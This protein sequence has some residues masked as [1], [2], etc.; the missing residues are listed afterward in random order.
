MPK[1]RHSEL[2]GFTS[3]VL[4]AFFFRIWQLPSIPSGLLWDE[5][6]NGL[7]VVPLFHGQ[8]PIF[9]EGHSGHE[10]LLFYA[11]AL[12]LKLFGW[13]PLALRLPAVFLT[14][15]AVAAAFLAIR[16][17]FGF[18]IA[19][20][21]SLL[22]A[23][24]QW[25]VSMGRLGRDNSALPLFAAVCVYWL[26]VWLRGRRPW[27]AAVFCGVSFG[28]VL[29]T[30]SPG[31]FLI[32]LLA[33]IWLRET[34]LQPEKRLALIRQGAVF[35]STGILVFAPLGWYF[36]RHPDAFFERARQLSIFN[37]E[38]G[39]P[40]GN[41][42]HAVRATA[43]MFSF[44]GEPGWDKTSAGQPMFDPAL[45]LLFIVGGLLA[46]CRWRRKE[47]FLV[48]AWTM[49]ML[50]PLTLTA[51]DLPDW[52]RVIG[53]AP[54][55]FVFPVLAADEL[56]RVGVVGRWVVCALAI[57]VVGFNYWQYFV[58]WEHASG[59][60]Q[61]YRPG[62]LAA[63]QSAVSSLLS[64]QPPTAVYFGAPDDHDAVTDFL[65]AGLDVQHPELAARLIGYD[66]RYTRV[67]PPTGAESYLI[68]DGRPQIL[69]LPPVGHALDATL[70][71]VAHLHGY[72]LPDRVEPGEQLKFGV[73]W[74]TL[75]PS[76]TPVTFFAHVLDFDQRNVIA[77]L[78]QNGFPASEWRGNER[79]LS[80]FPLQIPEA[81][82]DGAYWL[83][84]GAY[85]EDGKRLPI[86]GKDR[87]L[88]GPVVIASREAV[89]PRPVS[90]FEGQVALL[91][92]AVSARIGVLDVSLRWLPTQALGRDY[93][94]FVHVLDRTG[95][96]VAQADG[97]PAGGQWPTR[98]WL[99]GIPVED[100]RIVEL[101]AGVPAGR[102]M[103][104]A[105]LYRLD[106]GER[107]KASPEGPE[108][109][110]ALVGTVTLG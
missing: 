45:S 84:F 14:T 60:M 27:R 7:D 103:V 85:A 87:L 26:V 13:T 24:A 16:N 78:D 46:L 37:P 44:T 31:R 68:A 93:S 83:E 4:L 53:I 17:L 94:V 19:Y 21:A 90:N 81:T 39:A 71:D 62:V 100:T 3:V 41:W 38:F 99:A 107:L 77:S 2:V 65:I 50:A 49:V 108:P 54:A 105:G 5:G 80:M 8:L 12:S 57:A 82:P 110:S 64:P 33:L 59:R 73:S 48:L 55:V 69:S 15:L 74:S 109:D 70:G 25:Q 56:F 9:F 42:L 1:N 66:A 10:P 58:V 20:G 40:L 91:P 92:A 89:V 76:A 43:L 97:P 11:Q 104:A 95:K 88:V 52:G 96:L 86:A 18:R 102:Y 106:N 75:G 51:R 61:T 23:V 47:Y 101:P 79:V 22:M 36:I 32:F 6:G 72:D 67:L 30:Y 34:L 98:Y 63:G 35:A 29:Y 28:L